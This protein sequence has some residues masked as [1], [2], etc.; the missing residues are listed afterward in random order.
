[1]NTVIYK[2]GE[3]IKGVYFIVSGVVEIQ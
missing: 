2:E 1:M 3:L